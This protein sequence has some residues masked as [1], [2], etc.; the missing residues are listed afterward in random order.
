MAELARNW[1]EL[2][3]LNSGA[4]N[5]LAHLRSFLNWRGIER[6]G[7]HVPAK[8]PLLPRLARGLSLYCDKA[9]A[10]LPMAG[11]R[12]CEAIFEG[13]PRVAVMMC[14]TPRARPRSHP[15]PRHAPQS[16]F[17]GRGERS[18]VRAV[19]RA[20]EI[21]KGVSA[22][23]K[24]RLCRVPNRTDRARGGDAQRWLKQRRGEAAA[25]LGVSR[26]ALTGWLTDPGGVNHRPVPAWLPRVLAAARAGGGVAAGGADR[27]AAS[28]AR[29]RRRR[30]MR[31]LGNPG[32]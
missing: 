1:S 32:A 5:E 9:H 7:A 18:G 20:A 24:S 22:A 4:L 21:E 2:N 12:R 16:R 3:A 26:S 30:A 13:W 28:S 19:A 6:I 14:P 8:H 11:N 31:R 15:L 27:R 23:R 25:L 29:R 10:R 17:P